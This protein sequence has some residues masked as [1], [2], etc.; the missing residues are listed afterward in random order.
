MAEHDPDRV[1]G[2]AWTRRTRGKLSPS[3]RRR[4]LGAI[5]LAQGNYLVGRLKFATGRT[6]VGASHLS[7]A[8]LTPPDSAFAR[9]AEEAALEQPP[10]VVGHGYRTWMFGSAL[11][12]LDRAALDPELF[13]VA[14]LLHDHGIAEPVRGED[15]TLRSADRLEQ[16]G[17]GVNA[18]EADIRSAADAVTVHTT[19]GISIERDG[20]LGVYVQTGAMFDL[21]GLRG[22][23]L[24]W[25]YRGAVIRR[26]PRD[27]VTDAI[28]PMIKAEAR[29]N[30]DGRFGLL[31]RCGFTVLV[32]QNPLRPR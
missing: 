16:C 21:A 31:H 23:D 1:G 12:T 4:L 6:P 14:S 11:A 17:R 10:S 3:E 7:A 15:F 25:D 30:P 8:A 22:A 20:A 28:V 9:A 18:A 24:S 5:V 2:L 32:K 27:G 13:Y 29:A 19:P 26:H